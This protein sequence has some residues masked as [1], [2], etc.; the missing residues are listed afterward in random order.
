MKNAPGPDGTPDGATEFS[1]KPYSYIKFPNDGKLDTRESITI[2]AWVKNKGKSGPVVHY[3]ERGWG[4]HL[5]VEDRYRLSVRFVRRNGKFTKK[6]ISPRSK[7]PFYRA[8][9]FVG[10]AYDGRTGIATLFVNG[11]I[12]AR[13]RIGR[14]RL[15]TRRN[16]RVG[17]IIGDRRYFKGAIACVHIFRKALNAY[18]IRKKAKICFK[19]SK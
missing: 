5:W 4:V 18:Q 15:A 7:G 13:I 11:N 14:V 17:A 9:N 8:W 12:V 6:L 16:I 2:L 10:A 3:N 19:P 1:G